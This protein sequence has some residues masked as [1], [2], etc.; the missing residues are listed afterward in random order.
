MALLG[1]LPWA[2]LVWLKDPG[3]A[4]SQPVPRWPSRT[5]A[6]GFSPVPFY[7]AQKRGFPGLEGTNVITEFRCKSEP[8]RESFLLLILNK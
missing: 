8:I 7:V 2:W 6:G 5:L 4:G 3:Q 1:R